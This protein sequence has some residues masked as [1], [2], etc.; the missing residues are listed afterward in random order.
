[1]FKNLVLRFM[2]DFKE[3][4]DLGNPFPPKVYNKALVSGKAVIVPGYN[5]RIVMKQGNIIKGEV[6]YLTNYIMLILNKK[7]KNIEIP[8]EDIRSIVCSGYRKEQ[9]IEELGIPMEELNI[10]NTLIVS[11]LPYI[12][13]EYVDMDIKY[14][15]YFKRKVNGK[16]TVMY[17]DVIFVGNKAIDI[18]NILNIKE[19]SDEQKSKYRNY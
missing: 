12:V 18:C 17:E 16:I 9:Y 2:P 7:G 14:C 1:M 15:K 19:L 6:V 11:G 3:L 8:Y 5:I 13:G 10:F 4:S